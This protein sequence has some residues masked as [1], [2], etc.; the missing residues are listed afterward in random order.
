MDNN[1]TRDLPKTPKTVIDE[2]PTSSEYF[3]KNNIS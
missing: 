3:N 2:Y 1:D